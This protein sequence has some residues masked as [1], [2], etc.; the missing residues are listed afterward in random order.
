[1]ISPSQRPLPDNTQHSQQT[2][3]HTPCGIRTQNL[4]RRAAAYLRL[5]PRGHRDRHPNSL[6]L[7]ICS[8]QVQ[9]TR[10][11]LLKF[12]TTIG[13]T[14]QRRMTSSF[15]TSP[16]HTTPLYFIITF[17]SFISYFFT[18]GTLRSYFLFPPHF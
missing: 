9:K 11:F 7:K 17:L 2:N 1:M 4:N 16:L 5:R 8:L 6:D 18:N 3:I 13:E 14:I 10:L 15:T 12:P